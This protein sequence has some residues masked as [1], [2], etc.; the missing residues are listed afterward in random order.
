MK[1]GIWDILR[2]WFHR[3]ESAENESV[4]VKK[5]REPHYCADCRHCIPHM[6]FDE[7]VAHLARCDAFTEI[8][9]SPAYVAMHGVPPD[10][11]PLFCETARLYRNRDSR[12]CSKYERAAL[13]PVENPSTQHGPNHRY[14]SDRVDTFR[15]FARE[16]FAHCKNF[17]PVEVHIDQNGMH[18][19][20]PGDITH[21]HL[22]DP[23]RT[24]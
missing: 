21:T 9:D 14:T 19:E 13:A 7:P 23:E 3:F 5:K 12:W 24:F 8:P 16:C 15:A 10:P 6:F 17:G 18:A 2:T 11:R 4:A 20:Q 22:L 1:S